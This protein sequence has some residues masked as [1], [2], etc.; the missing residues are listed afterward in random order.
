MKVNNIPL[1]ANDINNSNIKSII[2]I[3]NYSKKIK[4]GSGL[5]F[6]NKGFKTT[7]I[8]YCLSINFY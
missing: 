6:K 8:I 4:K 7:Y 5:V 2:S 3:Y 1:F